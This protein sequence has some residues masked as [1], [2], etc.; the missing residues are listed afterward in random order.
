M[1]LAN[2]L[3]YPEGDHPCKWCECPGGLSHF[4]SSYCPHAVTKDKHS[5]R[6]MLGPRPEK[7]RTPY[8][9]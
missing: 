5:A 6:A 1:N 8:E 9:L 3:H 2:H 4:P 7:G